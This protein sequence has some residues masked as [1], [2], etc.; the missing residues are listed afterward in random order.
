MEL[1]P[2]II[3]VLKIVAVLAVVVIT[4][5]YITYR[6][7]L[8][9][10]IIES[11]E[12]RIAQPVV[13]AEKSVKK[14]VER[15]TKHIPPPPPDQSSKPDMEKKIILD[16]STKRP[17]K[18]IDKKIS[19]ELRKPN[20]PD[21]IEVVK[22]L[23][24]QSTVEKEIKPKPVKNLRDEKET[25]SEKNMASLGDQILDKYAED[26]SGEM[27]TLNTKKKSIQNNK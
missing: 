27:F 13:Y 9:K 11:P 2:I 15:I 4:F 21:R 22:S 26:E 7:K 12:K 17:V 5:S 24:P 10:G 16:P 19:K 14:I 18:K 3:S 6:I 25:T 23:S 1:V 8:K 20:K